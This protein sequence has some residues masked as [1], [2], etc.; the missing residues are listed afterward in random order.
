MIMLKTNSEGRIH[1]DATQ[2]CE[3]NNPISKSILDFKNFVVF[4]SFGQWRLEWAVVWRDI[5]FANRLSRV[6]FPEKLEGLV[7]T[8]FKLAWLF[9]IFYKQ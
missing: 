8:F 9:N 7:S 1:T 4:F 2:F 6:P 3:I 5:A